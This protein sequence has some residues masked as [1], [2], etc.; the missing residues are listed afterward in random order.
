MKSY[1]VAIQMKATEQYSHMVLF[2][3]KYFTKRNLGFVL[4]FYYRQ[5]CE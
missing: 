5:F 2:M 1:G 3:F 4:S